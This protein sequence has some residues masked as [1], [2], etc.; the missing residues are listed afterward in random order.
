MFRRS[1]RPIATLF[2]IPLHLH[3]SAVLTAGF[4][5][6]STPAIVGLDGSLT[7]V[8]LIGGLAAFLFGSSLIVH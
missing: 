7:S 3:W 8:L 6:M 5:A 2:G 4:V 1:S